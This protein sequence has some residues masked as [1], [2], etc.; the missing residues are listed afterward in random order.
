[1]LPH[2][3]HCAFVDR[4]DLRPNSRLLAMITGCMKP[5]PHMAH[6]A[7]TPSSTAIIR[8][9]LLRTHIM[10]CFP[11]TRCAAG[12]LS[13]RRPALP[14]GGPMATAHLSL[15]LAWWRKPYLRALASCCV[16][17]GNSPHQA[18][19]HAKVERAMRVVVQ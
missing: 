14:Y 16:G 10:D 2:F 1:M 4:V 3:G 18:K 13:L 5:L 17:S 9:S 12:Q 19:L 11:E 6:S 8:T 15:T 7:S